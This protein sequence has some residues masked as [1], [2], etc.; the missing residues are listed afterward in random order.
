MQGRVKTDEGGV[1]GCLLAGTQSEAVC[2]STA[3]RYVEDTRATRCVEDIIEHTYATTTRCIK[4]TITR[5]FA[6][7]RK[8]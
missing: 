6:Q 2:A 4:D 3:A 7:Q 5:Y 1:G 8:K